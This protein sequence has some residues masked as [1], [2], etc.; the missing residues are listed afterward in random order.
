[1]RHQ[2]RLR[3]LSNKKISEDDTKTLQYKILQSH[4]VGVGE[5]I[6]REISRLM[7]ITKLQSLAQGFSGVQL[8]T[9]VVHFGGILITMSFQWFL[10][11]AV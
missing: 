4:S 1:M 8:A 6:P 2:Y 10:K 11:K 3:I 7:L 9:L 5:P